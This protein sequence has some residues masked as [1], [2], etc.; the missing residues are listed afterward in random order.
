[1][2]LNKLNAAEYAN[3]LVEMYQAGYLDGFRK[4]YKTNT[5]DRKLSKMIAIECKLAFDKRFKKKVNKM[6]R[7]ERRRRK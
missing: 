2:E 1:M 4:A 3:G 6:I 5:A 7:N